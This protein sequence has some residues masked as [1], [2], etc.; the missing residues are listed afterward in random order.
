M[1]LN[2]N[3]TKEHDSGTV[4]GCR[5]SYVYVYINCLYII[6]KA[7]TRELEE[8]HLFNKFYNLTCYLN[9]GPGISIKIEIISFFLKLNKNLK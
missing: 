8:F 1:V 4:E 3:K 2:Y 9:M 5:L 6:E 7:N